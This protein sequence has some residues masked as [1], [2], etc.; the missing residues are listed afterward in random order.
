MPDYEIRNGYPGEWCQRC[1]RAVV[2]GFNV[3]DEIWNAIIKDKFNVVCLLC[4]DE[5]S[6][7]TGIE[8]EENIEFF[9]VSRASWEADCSDHL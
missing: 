9:P 5:L 4:F 3:P 2:V 7:G 8:W 6:E 1:N